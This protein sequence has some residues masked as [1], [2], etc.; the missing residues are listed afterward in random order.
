MSSSSRSVWHLLAVSLAICFLLYILV[1]AWFDEWA[2][3][4]VQPSQSE[5]LFGILSPSTVAALNDDAHLNHAIISLTQT[6]AEASSNYGEQ[7]DSDNLRELA[8]NLNQQ[9]THMRETQLRNRR[10]LSSAGQ[11]NTTA[12]GGGDNGQKQQQFGLLSGLGDILGL[13]GQ[14]TGGLGSIFS[15]L[16]DSLVGGLATPALFLGIG[17]GYVRNQFVRCEWLT[18]C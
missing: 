3:S 11:F 8:K 15:G 14:G 16:G 4:D 7:L 13:G 1:G 18:A 10:Q 2:T 9:L 5:P 12:E 17:I 6:V